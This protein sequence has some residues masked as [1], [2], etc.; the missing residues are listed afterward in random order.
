M[1]QWRSDV[2]RACLRELEPD[3]DWNLGSSGLGDESEPT[4]EGGVF[5][6]VEGGVL[7]AEEEV[8]S[9]AAAVLETEGWFLI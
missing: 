6:A 4:E 1:S 2:E 3:E 5:I 7:I 9:D 8:A